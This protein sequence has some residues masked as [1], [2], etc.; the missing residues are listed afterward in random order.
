MKKLLIFSL[1][2]L[3]SVSSFCQQI[4]HKTTFAKEQYIN[5]AN[6]QK[7]IGALL[8][9]IGGIALSTTFSGKTNFEILPTIAI[10]GSLAILASIPL[11]I[12]SGINEKKARNAKISIKLE[13]NS[14]EQITQYSF[15][16]VPSVSINLNF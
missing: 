16:S 7:V 13:Q 11:F 5:K 2:M 15:G 9:G 12:K 8:L 4:Q 1:L 10:S 3:F 14:F 6:K